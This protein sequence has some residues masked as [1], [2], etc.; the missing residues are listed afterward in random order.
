MTVQETSFQTGRSCILVP[1][2][3]NLNTSSTTSKLCNFEQDAQPFNKWNNNS[4]FSGLLLRLNK[5]I[6]VKLWTQ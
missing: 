1:E 4:Y 5:I 6:E 3:L 2:N